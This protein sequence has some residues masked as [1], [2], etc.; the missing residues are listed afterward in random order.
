MFITVMNMI[1]YQCETL[2]A[3]GLII[4]SIYKNF[5]KNLIKFSSKFMGNIRTCR[6]ICMKKCIQI[7]LV[8]DVIINKSLKWMLQSLNW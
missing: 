6:S 5:M 7:I 3:Q 2:K 1:F 4:Q 8:N